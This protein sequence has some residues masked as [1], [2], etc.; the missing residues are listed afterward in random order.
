AR[1]D[2]RLVVR[3]P[4]PPPEAGRPRSP[5]RRGE[6]GGRRGGGAR[7]GGGPALRGG[8]GSGPS[9]LQGLDLAPPAAAAH[10]LP[11]RRPPDRPAR[12]GGDP[13]RGGRGAGGP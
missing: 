12:G 5:D 8:Q 9:A 6:I 3:R 4:L 11:A 7:R 1:P 2:R 13:P 10:R